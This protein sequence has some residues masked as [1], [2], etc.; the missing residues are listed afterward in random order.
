LAFW[1]TEPCSGC[2]QPLNTTDS[3]ARL[4]PNCYERVW[5]DILV[6]LD[7]TYDRTQMHE[8]VDVWPIL[9]RIYGDGLTDP[10]T[11]VD[12]R[13]KLAKLHQL[14]LEE[15]AKLAAGYYDREARKL[16]KKVRR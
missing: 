11:G 15:E 9:R 8:W 12:D 4:C 6:K 3:N 13:N 2:K 10:V 1:S 16:T 7:P 5:E 14:R